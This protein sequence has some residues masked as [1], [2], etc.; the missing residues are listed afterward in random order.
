MD[1]LLLTPIE[2][3]YNIVRQYLSD[4]RP[5]KQSGVHY[6]A[7]T[8]QGKYHHYKIAIR[9]T[10]SKNTTIA[11]A[12]QKAIQD[13]NPSMIICLGIA[14]G[15]KDVELGDVVVA[16]KAYGYESGKETEDGPL[17]RPNV[18]QY[19]QELI[20]LA[21]NVSREGA[22]KGRLKTGGGQNPKV[23][24]GPIASGDKVIV[25]TQSPVYKILKQSFND[26]T[27]I[28]MEAIG[29]AEAVQA[30]RHI[31]SMNIRGVSDLLD[32][33]KETDGMGWQEMAVYHTVAFT[34]ELLNQI[35]F[36]NLKI[37][38]V[39]PKQVAAKVMELL[40]PTL[41]L[42]Q[43][44]EQVS[45]FKEALPAPVQEIWQ[46]VWPGMVKAVEDQKEMLQDTD[47]HP[48]IL[49]NLQMRLL[50][51]MEKNESLKNELE[52]LLKKQEVASP[53]SNVTISNSKNVIHGSDIDVGGDFHLGD[54]S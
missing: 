51:E 36:K 27:A 16:T 10:G 8:F 50:M 41:Q 53:Q 6:E 17:I 29:F 35:D 9:Q 42:P 30:Y 3:E 40:S 26:T 25:S 54:R 11:L 1:L 33:K 34:F 43:L 14:G 24:F 48:T 21:R 12:T 22:W 38:T 7:G 49:G 37:Y 20:D 44:L 23:V 47:F 39:E 5:L 19:D 32:G 46:K 18:L 28:E 15:V 31:R 45:P 52:A 4:L 13:L 2:T